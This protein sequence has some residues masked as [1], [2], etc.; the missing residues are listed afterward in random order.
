MTSSKIRRFSHNLFLLTSNDK[1]V[2][3]KG[4]KLSELPDYFIKMQR[5]GWENNEDTTFEYR[6]HRRWG[7]QV[8]SRKIGIDDIPTMKD[9]PMPD[10]FFK[11]KGL[12][13]LPYKKKKTTMVTSNYSGMTI[14]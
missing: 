8:V 7:R 10:F 3:Y 4:Y 1:T 6:W 5:P 9:A 12:V 2:L 14:Y 11:Y 13:L